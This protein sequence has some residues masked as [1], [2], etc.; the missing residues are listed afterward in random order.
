MKVKTD[1]GEK[2]E[3]IQEIQNEQI[4]SSSSGRGV[5]IV[6]L[7]FKGPIDQQQQKGLVWC[8]GGLVGGVGCRER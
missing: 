7:Q 5:G 4:S 6:L 3:D 1:N 8:L 2:E